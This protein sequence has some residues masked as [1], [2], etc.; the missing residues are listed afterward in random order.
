MRREK[1]TPSGISKKC[2]RC[3]KE[4]SVFN[5]KKRH[6]FVP[7]LNEK[8]KIENLCIGCKTKEIRKRSWIE[9]K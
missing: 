6:N 8:G 9:R 4:Y 7:F 2:P 3:G 5:N 1:S